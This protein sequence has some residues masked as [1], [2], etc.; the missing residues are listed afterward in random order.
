MASEG[1]NSAIV[2][3]GIGMMTAVG[4][5]SRQAFTSLRAGIARFVEFPGYEPVVRD[6]AVHFPE[7]LIAAPVSGIT[8]RMAGT[9]RLLALGVP[10][11]REALADARLSPSNLASTALLVA[12]SQRPNGIADSRAATI[13]TPRLA[14]RVSAN[15]FASQQFFANGSAGFLLALQQ[16]IKLLREEKAVHCA[17][18]GV[19]SWLDIETLQWLDD[20]RRLKS[21]GNPDGFIPGEAAAFLVVELKAEAE[22]RMKAPYGECDIVAVGHEKNAAAEEGVCTGEALSECLS[23]VLADLKNR[24]IR[25]AFVFCDMNGESFRAKEWGYA[26]A[27]LPSLGEA[28]PRIMHPADCIGDV[29][30]AMGCLLTGMAA[31][32]DSPPDASPKACL[33]WCSSD[34]GERGATAII[35]GQNTARPQ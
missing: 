26:L 4:H 29:G 34:G 33:V 6:P 11:L 12:G 31:L 9:E 30:A 17:V 24:G 23:G 28:G 18:G 21:N 16:A 8:D 27:R 20:C 5:R 32:E 7:P 22:R 19:D 13:V 14:L 3:T 25:P 10:A 2:I 35:K 15:P 1:N